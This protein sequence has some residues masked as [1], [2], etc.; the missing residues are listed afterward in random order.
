M[1]LRRKGRIRILSLKE[2]KDKD[3]CEPVDQLE[4][5]EVGAAASRDRD[6]DCVPTSL[7]HLS[8]QDMIFSLK[9][10]GT[11]YP[12]LNTFLPR[13]QYSI[14]LDCVPTSLAHL[15]QQYLIKYFFQEVPRVL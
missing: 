9:S 11:R 4:D 13:T 3:D 1:M 8:Q 15:A 6:L 14:N 7:A 2:R 5:K 10:H 12:V